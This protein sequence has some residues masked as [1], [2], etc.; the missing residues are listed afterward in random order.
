MFLKSLVTN[1]LSVSVSKLATLKCPV[2]WRRCLVAAEDLLAALVQQL[3][4]EMA[5]VCV[6]GPACKAGSYSQALQ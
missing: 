4:R 2:P 1:M 3:Q 6:H 5:R